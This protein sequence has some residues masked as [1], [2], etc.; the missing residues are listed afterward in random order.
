VRPEQ[1]LDALSQLRVR[2][3]LPVDD[4]SLPRGIRNVNRRQENGLSTF[5]IYGHCIVLGPGSPSGAQSLLAVRDYNGSSVYERLPAIR[6]CG[7]RQPPF[8]TSIVE[9]AMAARKSNAPL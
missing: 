5:L 6:A 2:R 7:R 8:R 3:T 4:G 9:F 1:R